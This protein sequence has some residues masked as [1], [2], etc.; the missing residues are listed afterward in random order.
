MSP[1]KHVSAPRVVHIRRS[2]AADAHV[3]LHV[4]HIDSS[5]LELSITA[6]EGDNPYTTTGT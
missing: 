4:S 3:L 1:S 5:A 2:D 6:T